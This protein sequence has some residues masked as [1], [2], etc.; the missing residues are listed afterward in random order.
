MVCSRRVSHCSGALVPANGLRI[1]SSNIGAA[2]V[3]PGD[4][5]RRHSMPLSCSQ[6]VPSQRCSFVLC[7]AVAHTKHDAEVVL[8]LVV[9][10]LQLADTAQSLGG[11]PA[12][13]L[14][15]HIDT[16]YRECTG[17]TC[18][19]WL[20]SC[21]PTQGTIRHLYHIHS[22][23]NSIL[24]SSLGS[25]GSPSGHRPP[26]AQT[27][28]GDSRQLLLCPRSMSAKSARE[29]ECPWHMASIS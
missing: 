15:R 10:A 1:V 2:L 9:V 29:G 23:P 27:L 24:P 3:I 8:S 7:D 5:R 11:N 6:L 14:L 18:C 22:R 25:G 13:L 21:V 20:R 28:Y 17:H 4:I 12:Q 26:Q 16:A 19:P